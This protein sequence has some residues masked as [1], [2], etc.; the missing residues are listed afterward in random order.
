M[1]GMQFFYENVYVMGKKSSSKGKARRYVHGNSHKVSA[2]F[3]AETLKAYPLQQAQ[4][5]N[6]DKNQ[7]SFVRKTLNKVSIEGTHQMPYMI[8]PQPTS[9][10]MLS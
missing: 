6:S 4:K 2:D 10:L 3:S 7:H 5:K 8:E 9:Y 1:L